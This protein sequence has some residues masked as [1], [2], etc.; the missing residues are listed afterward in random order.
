MH[1]EVQYLENKVW[2]MEILI[3]HLEST[4]NTTLIIILLSIVGVYQMLSL[5]GSLYSVFT[6]DSCEQS[7]GD[8]YILNEK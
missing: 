2:A 3:L 6:V 7:M 1:S 4:A 5:G 8:I